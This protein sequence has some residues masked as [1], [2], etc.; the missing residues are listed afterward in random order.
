MSVLCGGGANT[1]VNGASTCNGVDNGKNCTALNNSGT[2]CSVVNNTTDC[3]V[4]NNS[5][6]SCTVV[7]EPD[8][9][10][11]PGKPLG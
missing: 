4:V 8:P 3:T 2:S 6:G 1:T 10:P 11:Y 5:S 7:T 9:I